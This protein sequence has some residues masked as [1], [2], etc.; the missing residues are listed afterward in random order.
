MEQVDWSQ[1]IAA[2]PAPKY[3]GGT[4]PRVEID[5]TYAA[6]TGAAAVRLSRN[7]WADTPDSGTW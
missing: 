4:I 3:R 6:R 5:K 2:V 7:I 1:P